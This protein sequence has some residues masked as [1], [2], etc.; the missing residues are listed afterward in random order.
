MPP[1]SN[2]PTLE[3]TSMVSSGSGLLTASAFSM[4]SILCASCSSPMPVP[5]PVIIATGLPVMAATMALAAVVLPIPIS[6]VPMMSSPCFIS[7]STMSMPASMLL[8]AWVLVIAGPMYMSAVPA[9]M[10]LRIMFLDAVNFTVM[11][12]STM[13]TLAPTCRE[14]TFI[15]APPLK[16]FKTICAVTSCG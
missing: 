16:K 13:T 4:I 12:M 5:F 11:P 6:P 14:R 8:I 15:A 1:I 2:P 3:S 10:L 7:F 9:A